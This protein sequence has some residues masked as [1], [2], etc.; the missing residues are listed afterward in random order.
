MTRA[1]PLIGILA[2]VLFVV[3]GAI[4]GE[5]PDVDDPVAE[6]AEFY[7]ENDSDQVTGAILLMFAAVAFLCWSIQMR[8]ALLAGEGGAASRTTLG[9]AGTVV[10]AIGVAIQAG[11][12]ISLGEAAD[13]LDPAAV[14]ALHALSV[15][16]F[17]PLAVGMFLSLLGYGLAIVSTGVLPRWLG[18]VAVAGALFAITPVWFVPLFV[19]MVVILVSSVVL[20]MR[21]GPTAPSPAADRS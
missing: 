14:Q 20:A 4:A 15:N 13:D 10:F 9:F 17:P 11:L 16:M 19:L 2:V 3:A 1:L 7:T 5:I 18:Y 8:A 21:A 12:A 6:V